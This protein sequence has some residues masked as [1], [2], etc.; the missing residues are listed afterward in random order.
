MCAAAERSGVASICR[1]WHL[2]WKWVV[3][4]GEYPSEAN[5]KQPLSI[6]P[7]SVCT[8]AEE[9][10]YSIANRK[11]DPMVESDYS[12]R[13][14]QSNIPPRRSM[15]GVPAVWEM[16]KRCVAV[17]DVELAREKNDDKSE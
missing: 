17:E 1:I 15:Y 14:Y 16:W 12:I 8:H 3:E 4:A 7:H 5:C 9:E 6:H 2:R 10:E 11:L 13:R